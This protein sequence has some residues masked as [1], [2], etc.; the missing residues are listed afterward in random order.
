MSSDFLNDDVGFSPVDDQ[1]GDQEEHRQQHNYDDHDTTTVDGG[2]VWSSSSLVVVGNQPE[3]QIYA[4]E[5]IDPTLLGGREAPLG[6]VESELELDL[7]DVLGL[8]SDGGGIHQGEVDVGLSNNDDESSS[9]STS[10]L[11]SFAYPPQPKTTYRKRKRR[12][13]KPWRR[14]RM[15]ESCLPGIV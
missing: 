12:K 15:R 3:D 11:H 8:D 1:H 6:D 7:M 2:G 9:S 4:Y 14:R 5:T 13:K 10:S